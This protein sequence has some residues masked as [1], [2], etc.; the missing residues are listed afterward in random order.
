MLKK[1]MHFLN[2]KVLWASL[3]AQWLRFHAPNAG[4]TD[5]IPGQGTNIPCA[6]QHSQINKQT[7]KQIWNRTN[8]PEIS[9]H[10]CGQLNF[11]KSTKLIQ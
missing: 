3:V 7:N 8:N 1:K 5:L 9:P 2:I 11:D 6:A 4:G 10:I